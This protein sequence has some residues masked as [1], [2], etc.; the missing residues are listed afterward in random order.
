MPPLQHETPPRDI[1]PAGR[2][3]SMWP[4]RSPRRQ[5]TPSMTTL[6]PEPIPSRAT[7]S[8]AER[9]PCSIP[10]AAVIGRA[11]EPVLPSKSK[12]GVV[13]RRVEP[14]R[15]QQQLAMGAAD[16]VAKGLVDL[17]VCQPR[18]RGT[19]QRPPR[20]WRRPRAKAFRSR[21]TSA[22]GIAAGRRRVAAALA[23]VGWSVLART[24]PPSSRL[25]VRLRRR[26]TS[27]TAAL[28]EPMVSEAKAGLMSLAGERR[29]RR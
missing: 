5:S 4:I 1:M 3:L 15:F 7:R 23:E 19:R 26:S 2:R 27:T 11:T 24:A 16:L 6:I 8:P 20:R 28:P 14:Q 21:S 25:P 18:R 17:A 22:A 9:W 12:R 13:D 10:S 29:C